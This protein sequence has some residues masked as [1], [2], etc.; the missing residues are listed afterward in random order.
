MRT[1]SRQLLPGKSMP[2]ATRNA[3]L[4]GLK[5]LPKKKDY[6]DAAAKRNSQCNKHCGAGPA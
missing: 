4:H 5:T 1:Y 6:L 2:H 3:A